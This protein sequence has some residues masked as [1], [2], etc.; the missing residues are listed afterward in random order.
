MPPK[1]IFRDG[2]TFF[3]CQLTCATCS[4]TTKSGLKCKNRVCIGLPD[5]WLH[6]YANKYLRAKESN[7]PGA[8]KGLFA[9]SK[10]EDGILFRKGQ[11]VCAYSG[12]RI[13]RQELD[14][15]YDDF[16]APY[17]LCGHGNK[18][19]EDAACERGLGSLANGTLD[20]R[21]A[22][23]EYRVRKG[24]LCL[25]A[26]KNIMNG[27]ELLADYGREYGPLA[28]TNYQTRK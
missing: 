12:Q 15:R 5:C 23:I 22:N 7:I 25:I 27:H 26:T 14:R 17:G 2:N 19:C 11:I 24:K 1:F 3:E 21:Q 8:G 9:L 16:T 6:T 18:N 13:S 20:Y 10:T 4:A 28:M